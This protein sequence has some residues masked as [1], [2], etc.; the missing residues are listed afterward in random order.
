M[1][2]IFLTKN[3]VKLIETYL[4]FLILRFIEKDIYV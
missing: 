3:I 1:L 2:L 4:H